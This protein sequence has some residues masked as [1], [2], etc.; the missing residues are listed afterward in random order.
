M[1]HTSFVKLLKNSLLSFL[2]L[3]VFIAF[4]PNAYAQHQKKRPNV[5]FFLVDDLGYT[6]VEPFGTTFYET[7]NIKGL[8]AD[9]MRFTNAY[10]A[11]PVCSPTR[12]SIMTGKYPARLHE[13]DWFGAPQATAIV[14]N[15]KKRGEKMLLPAPYDENLPLTETTIAEAFK[16]AGYTTMIAGKWHLGS[17]EAHWPEHQGFDFNFGGYSAGHPASYFAPYHNPRLKDGPVGEYLPERLTK[18][19]LNFLDEHKDE[20]F[21]AYYALYSV[22]I[23]LQAKKEV[24]EKYEAKKKKLGITD[25]FGKEGNNDVRL[26]HG[27]TTYAAMV[28]AADDA[29]GAVIT[30]LKQ[31]KLY[32]NTIIVFFSDNGGVSISQKTPTS[33]MPLRGGKGWLYE[34]G[35]REPLI[36][37]WPG[38]T[39]PNTI[40]TEPVIST[41]FYPTLLQ[42]AGLPLMPQQ[43]LDGK[44]FVPLLKQ[45]AMTR[46]PIFWHYP[47]YADQRSSPG[48]AVR[49]GDWK[50]IRWYETQ[51]EELYNLKNDIG[52]QTNL[53][54]NNPGVAAKLR[55]ELD[56]WL[57][58]QNALMPVK[59]PYYI[60]K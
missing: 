42:M 20:P 58:A 15:E 13:T 57:T 46:G 8:A 41:D 11:C 38:V 56:D 7:P 55:K 9:A 3:G 18:E 40:C 2:L 48:S 27:N 23:P 12:V 22:H 53:L 36:V 37:K 32:D 43:H 14:K 34:G 59:N 16:K 51:T 49:D 4:A 28:E 1:P 50:L 54:Q 35:I 33:N 10:A 26:N 39:K 44:S 17:D 52:E 45:Q 19:T 30:K 31:L 25:Q 24:I 60:K 6:D 29:M 47:H 21:F 5:L